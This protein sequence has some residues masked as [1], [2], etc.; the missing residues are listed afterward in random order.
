MPIVKMNN[1][2][3]KKKAIRLGESSESLINCGNFNSRIH[4]VLGESYKNMMDFSIHGADAIKNIGKPITT[5]RSFESTPGLWILDDTDTKIGF[6]I[7]SD[8]YKKKWWKGTSYEVVFSNESI[9]AKQQL[10]VLD[11]ALIRLLDYLKNNNEPK[12]V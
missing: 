12:N 7:W 1:K 6:L 4:D 5:F 8:G 3:T 11:Q 2:L 10:Q 9:I